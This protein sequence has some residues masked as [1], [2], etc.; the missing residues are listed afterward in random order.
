MAKLP[1]KDVD[2]SGVFYTK[3]TVKDP[4]AEMVLEETARDRGVTDKKELTEQ[5]LLEHG[6]QISG[7]KPG[8]IKFRD[9][10]SMP[11]SGEQQQAGT[12]NS[13][14]KVTNDMIETMQGNITMTMLQK[15]YTDLINQGKS[16]TFGIEDMFRLQMMEKMMRSHDPPQQLQQMPP[17]PKS[18]MDEIKDMMMMKMLMGGDDKKSDPMLPMLL[19]E[20]AGIKSQLATKDSSKEDTITAILVKSMLDNK[21][22]T[23]NTLV[24]FEKMKNTSLEK[25]EAEKL[26]NQE[27]QSQIF[28]NKLD[29]MQ[30]QMQQSGGGKYNKIDKAI[31]D[32]IHENI[33]KNIDK[34]F[35]SGMSEKDASN[36]AITDLVVNTID[37]LSPTISDG[38]EALGRGMSKNKQQMN[39]P[40]NPPIYPQQPNNSQQQEFPHGSFPANIDGKTVMLVP[41]DQP[42]N[43]QPRNAPR[44]P[45]EDEVIRVA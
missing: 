9:G 33:T 40:A 11:I 41:Q 2:G 45:I 14:K 42:Q 19:Q 10:T 32:K 3:R 20:I 8:M 26:R 27:L 36:T 34:L 13:L 17:Q 37:R 16:G 18:P 35:G 25:I 1:G 29:Q 15:Q 28:N 30:Q 12:T 43:E 6:E 23:K 22:G 7:M 5:M 39:I 21:D 24:E 44:R 4:G 38:L 31:E